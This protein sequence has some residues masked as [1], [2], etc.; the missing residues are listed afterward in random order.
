[1]AFPCPCCGNKTLDKEPPGTY[2]IC[3]VCFWE[4]DPIQF[5]DPNSAGGA[6]S[7]SLITARANYELFGAC[8]E[9]MLDYVRAPLPGE[10]R[11]A[12]G[13]PDAQQ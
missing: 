12:N 11:E 13:S 10:A 9:E 7:P 5:A 3:P 1:M 4:D 2:D 6:N 8:E